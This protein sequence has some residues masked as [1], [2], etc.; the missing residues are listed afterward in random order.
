MSDWHLYMIRT[1]SGALYTGISNDVEKRFEAHCL[2]RGS[3]FLRA[4]GNLSLVYQCAV[5]DRSTASK[6]E[7]QLKQLSKVEKERLV[8]DKLDRK[9]LLDLLGLIEN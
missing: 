8:L 2:G 5:G 3:K 9:K 4:Q 1:A 7:Y 6:A